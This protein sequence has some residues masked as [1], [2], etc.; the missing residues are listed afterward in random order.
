MRFLSPCVPLT[1]LRITVNRNFTCHLVGLKRKNEESQTLALGGVLKVQSKQ[2]PRVDAERIYMLGNRAASRQ[3]QR[4]YSNFL[5]NQPPINNSKMH[6]VQSLRILLVRTPQP[7]HH[8]CL[9][10]PMRK[11]RQRQRHRRIQRPGWL[12]P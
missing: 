3:A 7:I 10:A 9:I 11:R 5:D 8:N 1:N 2:S 6:I 12:R 4:Y